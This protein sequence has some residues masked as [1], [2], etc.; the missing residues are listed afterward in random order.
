MPLYRTSKVKEKSSA[1]QKRTSS[2]LSIFVGFALLDP[3]PDLETPLNPD[4]IRIRIH[5]TA[6]EGAHWI[7]HRLFLRNLNQPLI[8]RNPLWIPIPFLCSGNPRR[9]P[10]KSQME[11][12][13][14]NQTWTVQC[15]Q[16]SIRP[17]N[18]KFVYVSLQCRKRVPVPGTGN[19]RTEDSSN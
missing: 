10:F 11:P 6:S 8:I 12:Q 17:A 13:A 9:K 3:D 19:E 1:P 18:R 7:Q 5:N 2:T 4:P 14:R 16:Y 15:T